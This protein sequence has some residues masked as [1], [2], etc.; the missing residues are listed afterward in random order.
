M[1]HDE[2]ASFLRDS[3]RQ[4]N[5]AGVPG[6]PFGLLRKRSGNN[7]GGYSC[8]VI[9]SGQGDAQR[10]YDVLI[11]EDRPTWSGRPIGPDIRVDVCE[12]Q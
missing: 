8:D 9:C 3:V 4:F 11:D 5:Q 12:I 10:Q 7:C 1:S 6:G 2:R